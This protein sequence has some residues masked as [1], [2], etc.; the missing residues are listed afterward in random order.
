MSGIVAGYMQSTTVAECSIN[1]SVKSKSK[2]F[3]GY[4][5]GVTGYAREGK[6]NNLS[7]SGSVS[8]TDSEKRRN[9]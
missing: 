5:G 7:V 8:V 9:L 4:A 2:Y 3:N 1:G 6:F